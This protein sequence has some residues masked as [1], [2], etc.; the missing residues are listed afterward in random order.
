VEVVAPGVGIVDWQVRAKHVI[1]VNEAT[2]TAARQ[3]LTPVAE[4]AGGYYDG[5][6]TYA[7]AAL[8]QMKLN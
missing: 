2:I 7:D 6:D 5:W 4:A 8:D 1:I 3:S